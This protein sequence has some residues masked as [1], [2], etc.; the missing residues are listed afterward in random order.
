VA[1]K[2]P[3][4]AEL[5][6][7]LFK[8][9][10]VAD[11]G[12]PGIGD[13][14]DLEITKRG[15][16]YELVTQQQSWE[17]SKSELPATLEYV[18]TQLLLSSSRGFIHLHGASASAGEHAVVVLGAS[19]AGKSSM[20]M[21][22][23]TSGRPVL[24]DDVLFVDTKGIIHP[25]RRN[26]KVSTERGIALGIDVTATP[27]WEQRAG[28]IWFDPA[29]FNGGGWASP[30]PIGLIAILD[31]QQDGPVKIETLSE[32][33][34]AQHLLSQ[35]MRTGERPEFQLETVMNIAETAGG[36]HIRYSDSVEMAAQLME[37]PPGRST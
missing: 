9:H 29:G 33:T 12:E 22:W 18:L 36:V 27:Y 13:S 24:G 34:I 30:L 10:L 28:E 20:A 3:M 19:E 21:A 15:S 31:R 1:T 8:S 25:F 35:F 17:A 32:S 5:V 11:A 6:R 26:F 14:A 4:A 7:D 2:D 37:L 16:T 23:T